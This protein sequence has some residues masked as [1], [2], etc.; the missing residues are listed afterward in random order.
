[1]TAE[2]DQ[3]TGSQPCYSAEKKSKSGVVWSQSAAL[4][5]C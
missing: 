1:M 2:V 5:M 3:N 4:L